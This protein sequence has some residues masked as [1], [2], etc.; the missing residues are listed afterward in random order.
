MDSLE[1]R[2]ETRENFEARVYKNWE[3]YGIDKKPYD[4]NPAMV[5]FVWDIVGSSCNDFRARRILDWFE[6]NFINVKDCDYQSAGESFVS[7]RGLCVNSALLYT[8]MAKIAGIKANVALVTKRS[9]GRPMSHMCSAVYLDDKLVLVDP[10]FRV[11]D[12]VYGEFRIFN[13]KTARMAYYE[14]LLKFNERNKNAAFKFEDKII[15]ELPPHQNYRSGYHKQCRKYITF[16]NEAVN[17]KL[18]AQLMENEQRKQ[19]SYQQGF[20]AERVVDSIAVDFAKSLF[21]R[22]LRR[23]AVPIAF[24]VGLGMQDTI[25]LRDLY[26]AARYPFM[27]RTYE[28]Q[29]SNVEAAS[30]GKSI[31]YEYAENLRDV[32]INFLE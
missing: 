16:A 25:E 17:E 23:L 19:A 18:V 14:Y 5:D 15:K 1:E 29:K 3:R 6:D 27:D 21:F 4:A 13:D 26:N 12:P 8:T 22:G 2:V 20:F 32:V 30:S 9:N 11:F 10:Y 24:S 28:G 7:R 31:V